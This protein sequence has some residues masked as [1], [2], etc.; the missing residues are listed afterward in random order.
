MNAMF[1]EAVEWSH[2]QCL[3]VLELLWLRCT[4][5]FTAS[6]IHNMR[7]MGH[8]SGEMPESRFYYVNMRTSICQWARPYHQRV[9]HCQDIE[10]DAFVHICLVYDVLPKR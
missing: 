2:K 8:G 1:N 7:K 3:R 9:F 4:H 10:I 6:E 5:K